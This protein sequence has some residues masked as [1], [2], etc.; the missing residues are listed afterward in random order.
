[1]ASD[2]TKAELSEAMDTMIE[3]VRHTQKRF[4]KNI[5]YQAF[6]IKHVQKRNHKE[7]FEEPQLNLCVT[8][9]TRDLL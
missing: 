8:G 7:P 9:R 2:A 3:E 4:L 5:L 1:M 6:Y